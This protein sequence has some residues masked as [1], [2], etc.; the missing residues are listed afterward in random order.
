MGALLSD[1]PLIPKDS[2]LNYDGKCKSDVNDI[3]FNLTGQIGY[4]VPIFYAE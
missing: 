1:T 4:S 2:V 3:V